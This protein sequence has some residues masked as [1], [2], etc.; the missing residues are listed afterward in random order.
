MLPTNK[1]CLYCVS[2]L[3]VAGV[4]E[5]VRASTF[6]TR[7]QEGERMSIVPVY[8]YA[9]HKEYKA[10]NS[11][12]GSYVSVTCSMA[13]IVRYSL[14]N[15]DF[16][17]HVVTSLW[18]QM[19]YCSIPLFALTPDMTSRPFLATDDYR[20]AE[21]SYKGAVSFYLGMIGAQLVFEKFLGGNKRNYQLLH[22]GDSKYFSLTTSNGQRKPDYVAINDR[23]VPYALVEA[24]G[25][26]GARVPHERVKHAKHQL[27][28]ASVTTLNGAGRPL[29][30][31]PGAELE[32]HVV[33][34]S[35]TRGVAS[36][37]S[38][39][40][41][42]DV[43]PDGAGEGE[44]TIKLDGAIYAH[45]MPMLQWLSRDGVK[46]KNINGVDCDLIQIGEG[47]SA[48][49]VSGLREVIADGGR[50]GAGSGDRNSDVQERDSADCFHRVSKFFH[51]MEGFQGLSEGENVSIGGDGVVVVLSDEYVRAFNPKRDR[52]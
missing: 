25:T 34:S 2:A 19:F 3:V 6:A 8:R 10:K 5:G 52:E 12:G 32:K 44:L 26:S 35:F 13:D 24:K 45:Y 49:L 31:T 37:A 17:G 23:G 7:K 9:S 40:E 42:C 14:N 46:P 48:G 39:W 38:S 1:P 47:V 51:S 33:A 41:L 4:N 16:E 11:I 22:A 27:Q 28:L 29:C 43:D 20:Y 15:G 21:A 50:V 36:K 18:G 30:V